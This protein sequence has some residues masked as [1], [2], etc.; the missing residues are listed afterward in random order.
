MEIKVKGLFKAKGQ[1]KELKKGSITKFYVDIDTD[2]EYPTIAE[3]QFWNDKVN[4]EHLKAGDDITILF[5]I[6]GRKWTNKEGEKIFLQSLTAWRI[7]EEDKN[8]AKAEQPKEAKTDNGEND[9][10]P[11]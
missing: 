10:L 4:I 6:N 9:I 8:Q 3:F 5:N 7:V 11:F 1:V 2:S